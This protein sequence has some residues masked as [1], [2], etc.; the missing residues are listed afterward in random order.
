M[1][2]AAGDLSAQ[3]NAS[4]RGL[5]ASEHY[6]LARLGRLPRSTRGFGLREGLSAL[7]VQRSF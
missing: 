1:V 3:A 2:W 7:S 6:G 5:S 4:S